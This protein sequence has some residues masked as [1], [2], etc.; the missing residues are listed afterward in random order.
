MTPDI[1][2]SLAWHLERSVGN[3]TREELQENYNDAQL[4]SLVFAEVYY[5]LWPTSVSFSQPNRLSQ[6]LE[7][8]SIMPPS[9]RK[10]ALE[11]TRSIIR[12]YAQKQ[13]SNL[14]QSVHS[15]LKGM[16]VNPTMEF[17]TSDGLHAID[18]VLKTKEGVR[19]A[20]EVDGPTHFAVNDIYHVKGEGI[21]RRRSLMRLGWVVVNVPFY[22]WQR[23]RT[24]QAQREWLSKA[25]KQAVSAR[26]TPKRPDGPPRR[27]NREHRKVIG[28]RK[29]AR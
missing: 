19:I 29:S 17:I 21:A 11:R 9:L 23:L 24:P 3:S 13:P 20:I 12:Q 18:I 1:R 5:H 22:V 28:Y 8:D 15:V 7:T 2:T 4:S 26:Q 16:G 27:G 6:L 14:Q 10:L 25:L